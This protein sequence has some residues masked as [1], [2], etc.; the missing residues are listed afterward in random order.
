VCGLS[1]A[2]CHQSLANG[3]LGVVMSTIEKQFDLTSSESSW[4]ASAYEFGPIPVLILLSFIGS[5]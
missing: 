1:F 4:I 5:W 3:L 2:N